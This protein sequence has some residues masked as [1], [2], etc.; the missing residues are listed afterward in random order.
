MYH[1]QFEGI[2]K[3]R[4]LVLSLLTTALLGDQLAAEFTLLHLLSS[5]H[6]RTDMM[7]LG[8]MSLNL[9]HCP[10][11]TAPP[12]TLPLAPSIHKLLAQILT[13]VS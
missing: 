1:S 11:T 4:D 12:P 13:Q 9:T 10:G 8:K 5:V 3:S 2:A 7:T 6:G